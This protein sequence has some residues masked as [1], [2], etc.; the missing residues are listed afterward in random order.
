MLFQL[1]DMPPNPLYLKG[2]Q[3][4]GCWPCIF[5]RKG[6]IRQ[7]AELDPK[8]I[9]MIRDLEAK[10]Q[11]AAEVRQAVKGTTLEAQGHMRP[12]FFTALGSLRVNGASKQ[13]PI[14]DVVKWSETAHGGKEYE[15]FVD[16]SGE[17]C[18]RWGICDQPATDGPIDV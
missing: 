15:P 14:D 17:G 6:E 1:T 13:I 12:T 11:S 9:D 7:I 18:L 3:R 16:R 4:V 5:A 2:A 8:R 10:V